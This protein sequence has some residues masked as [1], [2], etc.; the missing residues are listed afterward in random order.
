MNKTFHCSVSHSVSEHNTVYIETVET[1][2]ENIG[3][4]EISDLGAIV[5]EEE[6]QPPGFVATPEQQQCSDV[7]P[8]NACVVRR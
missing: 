8:H 2:E 5:E 6:W 3:H 1:S 7:W 4:E